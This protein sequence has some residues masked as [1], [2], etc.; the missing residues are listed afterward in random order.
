MIKLLLLSTSSSRNAG[1]L[2]NSVRNLGQELFRQK[3]VKP[4]VLVFRDEHTD[5]DIN[6][7]EPLPV[8]LY[9]IIGP[10]GVAFTLDL[11]NKIKTALPDIIHVQGIYLFSSFVN[12]RYSKK[13]GIPY[14]ISPRG[15]LDPWI[16]N[17]NSL[18]K[19]IGFFLYEAKHISNAACLHALCMPEYKAIRQYG[20]KN[21]IAILPNGVYLPKEQDAE[22]LIAPEWKEDGRKV[23]LFLSRLHPKKGIENLM[24]AWSNS[25]PEAKNWKIV[26]AGESNGPEYANEL[27]ALRKELNLEEDVFFIGPQFHKEKDTAF[28]FA[29][30]FILPSYSE[31]MP[32]AILEAWSYGLPVLMTEACNI[33]E[34]FAAGA[35]LKIDTTPESIAGVLKEF[36]ALPEEKR[37]EI[38]K[39]GYQLVKDRYTWES[40][41]VQVTELY[42]WVADRSRPVP[43]FI[44]LD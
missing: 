9:N 26:I 22:T 44:K 29:D 32:M 39:N 4:S 40:I 19:K 33:E 10:P 31:G 27:N 17:N 14:I 15:M 16:L 3:R 41:A 36:F 5:E 23:L 11:Y 34:G 38:G 20:A 18:K 13:R 6:A 1:G 12:L 2:Y 35:A 8:T 43:D 28:R 24:K 7:Y 42:E 25:G 37:L 30:A 21:P